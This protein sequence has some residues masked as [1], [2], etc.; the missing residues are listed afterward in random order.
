MLGRM[1]Y[2]LTEESRRTVFDPAWR[3]RRRAHALAPYWRRRFH[4]FGEGALLDTPFWLHG[5]HKITIGENCVILRGSWLSVEKCVWHQA[6]PVLRIGRGVTMRQGVTISAS[7]SVEIE[8]FV[9]I[10]GGSTILDSTHTHGTAD[11]FATRGYHENVLNQPS[12]FGPV[13]I[14]RGTWIGDR[15]TVLMGAQIGAHCTIGSNSL[16]RGEIPDYSVAM[17]IPARV[18][19]TTR[20]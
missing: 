13:R 18:V 17:G 12:D 4:S 9:G 19:G 5:A 6:D 10:G 15:V 8:D 16:V 3:L 7:V 1:R 20:T 14:G 2:R 11:S